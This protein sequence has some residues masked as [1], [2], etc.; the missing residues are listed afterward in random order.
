M[1]IY[2]AGPMSD[3]P[4]FN[5]PAFAVAT[6]AL[7]AAGHL[8][9]SPHEG[10]DPNWSWEEC[11]RQSLTDMLLECHAIALLP[12]WETSR[13]ACI[14]YDIAKVLGFKVYNVIDNALVERKV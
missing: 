13:G 3:K 14:E 8:I 7:R 5:Y 2:L 9:L 11:L 1:I 12:G 4:D 6:E 10:A